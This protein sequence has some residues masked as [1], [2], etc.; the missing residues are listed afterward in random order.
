MPMLQIRSLTRPGLESVDLDL[1]EGEAVALVG[2]SGAGKTILLRAIA[3]LDPNQGQISLNGQDRNSMPAPAWRRQV[4]YLAAEPG[5]WTERAGDHFPDPDAGRALLPRLALPEA[6]MEQQI[7]VLSTGERHRLALARVLMQTPKVLLLDEPTS[8]LDQGSTGNVEALLR[9]R[10][11]TGTAL[12]FT[13][14]DEALAQRLAG[15]VLRIAKGR[16]M[17]TAAP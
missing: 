15:R 12:L 5:W 4:T 2:A 8:G 13:T 17:A 7:A 11:A 16:I 3:D 14:H 6:I 10:L 9:E 1:A